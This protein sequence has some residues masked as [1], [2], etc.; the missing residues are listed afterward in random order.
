MGDTSFGYA[1]DSLMRCVVDLRVVSTSVREGTV[2]GLD[3]GVDFGHADLGRVAGDFC[4]RW[5]QGVEVL[6][7]GNEW[8]G[9]TLTEAVRTD[10]SAD[11]DASAAFAGVLGDLGRAGV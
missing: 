10:V 2:D 1:A 5:S 6:V 3:D 9:D 4:A 11:E 7:G 8:L